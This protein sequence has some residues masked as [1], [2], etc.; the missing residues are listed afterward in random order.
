MTN[1]ISED[2]MFYETTKEVS[3]AAKETYL[4]KENTSE[5]FEVKRILNDLK[6]GEL[7]VTQYFN[8]LNS[9]PFIAQAKT[10]KEAWTILANTY[11]KPSRGRIKQVKTKLKN[12]TKGSQNVIE[13]LHSVKA[14]ADELA[15]LGA[16]LDPEDLTDKIL[17]G[18]GDDYKELVRVVQAR[19][20]FITFDELHEKL[21]SFEA[22][23]PAITSLSI[24][25]TGSTT[26]SSPQS[27]FT[28]SDVLWDLRL[29]AIL[30]QGST[31]DG[32]IP[33]LTLNLSTSFELIFETKPNYAKL[34]I[35]GCLCYPW[36]RPYSFHKLAPSPHP[37][38][39]LVTL[40]P[41]VPISVFNQP[42]LKHV[43]RHVQFVESIFPYTTL[44]IQQPRLTTTTFSNW[45]PPIITIPIP[46]PT[47]LPS[48]TPKVQALDLASTAGHISNTFPP[49]HQ[50]GPTLQPE[51]ASQQ[52]LKDSNWRKAMFEEYDALIRNG[53]WE[54]VSPTGITNLVGYVNNAFLQGTLSE[55]VYMVQLLSF[56]DADKP[57][58]VCKLH[59]AIYGLK[60]APW[61]WYH[62]L[63]QFLVDSRFKNSHSD[64]SLFILHAGTDLLYLL[65]YVDD[66]IIIGNSNDLVSQVV[67]CLAQRFSLKD[68]G[69][70]SYFLGVEVVSHRH[71]LL[72]S[73]R[74][75]IKDLLT[76]TNMQTTKPVHTP[77][78]TSSSSIKL[79]Y[80]SPL[81]N[82]MEYRTI[83]GS[84]Q[85]L[86][87]TRPNISF[88][89]NK[90]SQFMHQPTDEHW[91][92]V[93][94]ILRYLSGTV[95]DGLLLH[96]A[97]PLS[98]HAFSD[99][100]H[101]FSDVDWASNKDDYSSTGAY[102]VYL[103]NNLI[104]WISKK[105]KIVA[106][107][108]TEAEYLSV[109]ATAVELCW[110]CSL[111]SE[112]CINLHVAIDYHFLRDQVQSGA[113]RVAHVSSV[114]QL[115]DLL[116][117]PLP[118]SQFQKLRVKIGLFPRGLS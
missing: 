17:D 103:G 111:L 113:L 32:I 98:L 95:N 67:E 9:I 54:L 39:F 78:P 91:T 89:V 83:V 41:K 81:S 118:H 1:E 58:H 59:K 86:S 68:L 56:I 65:V 88:V 29:R 34:K 57:T 28:L 85:Y 51:P 31:K 105:Q 6:Q 26:L 76:R 102:L 96:R 110:V 55:T 80:G 20:T 2:F 21:L 84:L 4:D 99:S 97:S 87:L 90:M 52:A 104:S 116:T 77:L 23:A 43:S 24:T 79:S 70:L 49:P 106:R 18:L 82:P 112:L 100:I 3:D 92:L 47:Q 40:C 12:S 8:A 115:A 19:D 66:I 71:G 50:P 16:P 53:T 13:Y 7:I 93:K 30:F 64:T 117:K 35:F 69:P 109:V 61:A 11:A 108:S 114:D 44:N 45:I 94:R 33:T 37:V 42:P 10:A 36:L 38:S 62:E 72:F 107:S 5:L 15:I 25:H 48:Y 46:P 75:Y 60:Q 74:R 101:A 63:C 14:C 27:T 73:Q 22:S